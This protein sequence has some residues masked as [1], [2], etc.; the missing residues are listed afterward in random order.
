[1][2]NPKPLRW[3]R[4]RRDALPLDDPRLLDPTPLSS[5]VSPEWR[6]DLVDQCIRR[7]MG[8]MKEWGGLLGLTSDGRA[9]LVRLGEL[10]NV[11]LQVERSIKTENWPEANALLRSARQQCEVLAF[12]LEL[13]SGALPLRGGVLTELASGLTAPAPETAM[14][15]LRRHMS[16][17]APGTDRDRALEE[18]RI[19]VGRPVAVHGAPTAA[20]IWS[21]V[22]S[23]N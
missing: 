3:L 4:P 7:V 23:S 8:G 10:R 11:L 14:A 13:G 2:D 9:V 18:V 5:K 19:L 15:E 12:G 1:M 16:R 20:G 21:R 22:R 17:D 6:L